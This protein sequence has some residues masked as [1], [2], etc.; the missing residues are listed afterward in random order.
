MST[1]PG[2]T[3]DAFGLN[4]NTCGVRS[5]TRF[6]VQG[7]NSS[8]KVRRTCQ[9]N[10]ASAQATA[11]TGVTARTTRRN[12]RARRKTGITRRRHSTGE[13][14]GRQPLSN[15]GTVRLPAVLQAVVQTAFA[16]LPEL[17]F[18][19]QDAVAAPPGGTRH[20]AVGVG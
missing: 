19:G 7:G 5:A 17:H 13:R 10:I 2:N 4:S 16:P 6:S 15:P 3:P 9:R 12:A 20:V 1:F 11:M 14:S 8:S 18:V